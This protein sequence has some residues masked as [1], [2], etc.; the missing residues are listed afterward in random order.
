MVIHFGRMSP[1]LNQVTA[2]LLLELAP[3]SLHSLTTFVLK[4]A[5]VAFAFREPRSCITLDKSQF[6]LRGQL[7]AMLRLNCWQ[8][9]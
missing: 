7:N 4:L 2:G 9:I 1:F 3:L 8:G 5:E 6:K